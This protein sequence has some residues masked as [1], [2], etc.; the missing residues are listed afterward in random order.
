MNEIPKH[1]LKRRKHQTEGQIKALKYVEKV[2]GQK[3]QR[4]FD[5]L[6]EIKLQITKD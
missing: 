6:D 2:V 4:E 1:E 3:I 5:A